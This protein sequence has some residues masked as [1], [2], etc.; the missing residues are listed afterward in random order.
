MKIRTDFVTNSSSS[1]FI[2]G[3]SSEENI[4]KELIDGFPSWAMDS[5]GIVLKDSLSHE[6]IT[7][8][9][10]LNEIEEYLEWN[11][12]YVIAYNL[13]SQ[14]GGWSKAISYLETTEEGKK[15]VADRIQKKMN[16]YR[17]KVDRNNVFV[18]LEYSDN[19]CGDGHPGL[20][21]DVMPNVKSVVCTFN[22]H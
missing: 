12:K 17:Q 19:E 2:L 4:T 6:R 21:F 9:E 1:S 10:V 11:E 5:A 3:F 15:L 22:N 14:H 13:Q 7:K 16:E 20:E 8:E 18:E